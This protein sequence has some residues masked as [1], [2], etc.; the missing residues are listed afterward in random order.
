MP[1]CVHLSKD[2]VR[3]DAGGSSCC[4]NTVDV[5]RC[6]SSE[7]PSEYCVPGRSFDGFL[8][9]L[10]DV[11]GERK[12]VK[13]VSCQSCNYKLADASRIMSK[14]PSN[15]V[16]STKAM[17]M[18]IQ[19]IGRND[20]FSKRTSLVIDCDK[21]G[22]GDAVVAAW[23]AE[24][25]KGSDIQVTL[26]ATGKRNSFLRLL[27][28]DPVTES[29]EAVSTGP[30]WDYDSKTRLTAD[31]I[32]SWCTV[33]GIN[34]SWKRPKVVVSDDAKMRFLPR[35]ESGKK[36]VVLCPRSTWKNREWPIDYWRDMLPLL[37]NHNCQAMVWGHDDLIKGIE[38]VGDWEDCA[39]A[40][41]CADLVVGIDS[42]PIHLS[43][44][45][46]ATCLA[47]LGPTTEGVFSHMPNVHCMS[48][49]KRI[50]PCSGCWNWG[51]YYLN[52]PC[53][54]TC[55]SLSAILPEM[56]FSKVLELLRKSEREQC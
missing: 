47:L 6:L 40:V 42:A 48:T 1:D 12:L 21:N 3:I 13:A 18:K 7:Q 45:I 55:S 33:L 27:G 34:M 37:L 30:T 4:G 44:T 10:A 46:G 56:V 43:G 53:I 11:E 51:E 23:L 24:G 38:S 39:A 35:K 29:A 41:Q 20:I 49:E 5:R 26:K 16:S 54:R 17:W 19:S 9:G 15:Y 2:M 14:L 50:M 8:S 25:H 22:Y 32:S 52:V 31:R 28:Q 36:L